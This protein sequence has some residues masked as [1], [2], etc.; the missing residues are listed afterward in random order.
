MN[1]QLILEA[2]ASSSKEPKRINVRD[3]LNF[4]VAT[5]FCDGEVALK[6][7]VLSTKDIEDIIVVSKNFNLIF[8]NLIFK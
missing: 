6:K 5:V 8:N 1:N 3:V 7:C 4:N 2:K